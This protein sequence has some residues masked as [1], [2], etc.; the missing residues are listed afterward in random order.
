MRDQQDVAVRDFEVES[1]GHSEKLGLK[2]E[3]EL[4]VG[5][6]SESGSQAEGAIR[7]RP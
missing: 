2:P 5:K 1:V 7:T 4:A 3:K 6:A